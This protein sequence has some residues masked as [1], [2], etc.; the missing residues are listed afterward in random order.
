MKYLRS[1]KLFESKVDELYDDNIVAR[2]NDWVLYMFDDIYSYFKFEIDISPKYKLTASPFSIGTFKYKNGEDPSNEI[3]LFNMYID[4]QGNFFVL[5]KRDFESTENGWVGMEKNN[6]DVKATSIENEDMFMFNCN[7]NNF[8]GIFD[9]RMRKGDMSIISPILKELD[10]TNDVIYD[11]IMKWV[12]NKISESTGMDIFQDMWDLNTKNNSEIQEFVKDISLGLEDNGFK[13]SVTFP[14][15][16]FSNTQVVL[17]TISEVGGER[18][19]QS[20][21]YEEVSNEVEHID[22]LLKNDYGFSFKSISYY[23]NGYNMVKSASVGK[24]LSDMSG[25]KITSILKILYEKRR[26]I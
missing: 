9:K 17:I 21:Y 26:E 2:S 8:L 12:D 16:D 18:K 10:Y 23:K 1:Y 11:T 3:R 14:N 5:I 13:A 15:P 19:H 4:K 7:M 25:E 20:Y 24:D 22:N 6:A